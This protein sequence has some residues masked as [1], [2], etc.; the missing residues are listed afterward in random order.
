MLTILELFN[1]QIGFTYFVEFIH[2]FYYS[3][4]CLERKFRRLSLPRIFPVNQAVTG[5]K[6]GSSTRTSFRHIVGIA[7]YVSLYMPT[8]FFQRLLS[9]T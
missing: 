9:T 2:F 7:R 1:C 4:M 3:H 6:H 8:Q 5:Q